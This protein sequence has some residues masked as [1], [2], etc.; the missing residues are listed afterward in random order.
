M[1]D[2]ASDLILRETNREFL[3]KVTATR[4]IS[5][6]WGGVAWFTPYDARAVTSITLGSTLLTADVDYVLLP[7]SRRD[8]VFTGARLS[9]NLTIDVAPLG[10][11]LLSVVGDWGWTDVPNQIKRACLR[12]VDAWYGV[13]GPAHSEE[14]SEATFAGDG[15]LPM[16]VW[17]VIKSYRRV[18]I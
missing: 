5:Y 7:T 18:F 12:I 2:A 6:Q 13:D 15:M 9:S 3:P 17:G 14:F 4:M 1:I 10:V 16:D 11:A 8:G